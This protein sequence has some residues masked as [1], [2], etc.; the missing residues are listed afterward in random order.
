MLSPDLI[1][2]SSTLCFPELPFHTP[3][4]GCAMENETAKVQA[5]RLIRF[6]TFE[7]NGMALTYV[8]A[9]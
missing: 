4:M 8:N 2:F 6:L 7:F 5:T 9:F 3:V 1:I